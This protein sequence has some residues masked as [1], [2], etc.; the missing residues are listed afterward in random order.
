MIKPNGVKSEAVEELTTVSEV[1][2]LPEA[3]DDPQDIDNILN[4]LKSLLSSVEKLQKVRQEVGD[5]KPLI[6]RMLDG[7]LVSGEEL[8][9]L[10]T[11]VSGLARL[12][13]AYSDHQ[14]ALTKAQPARQL[15]DQ[16]L[17]ER[18]AS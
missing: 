9:Q 15:L 12:V 7:E 13:R 10:K 14:A 4:S 11:G 5:I 6:G 1:E 3:V 2:N 8:E 16:V 17:K 18:K